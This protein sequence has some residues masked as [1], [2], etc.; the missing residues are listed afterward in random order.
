LRAAGITFHM[1]NG[2][3]M[4]PIILIEGAERDAVIEHALAQVQ[5]VMHAVPDL[6]DP[7]GAGVLVPTDSGVA[8]I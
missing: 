1:H 8:P 3:C 7:P 4:V 5:R 2:H 6:G